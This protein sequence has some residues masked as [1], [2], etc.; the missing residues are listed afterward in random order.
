MLS[1][2]RGFPSEFFLCPLYGPLT[3]YEFLKADIGMLSVRS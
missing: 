1:N 2:G 3:G